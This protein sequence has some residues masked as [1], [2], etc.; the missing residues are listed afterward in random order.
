MEKIIKIDP[1]LLVGR[2]VLINIIS[3]L[4]SEF[5]EKDIILCRDEYVR[6]NTLSLFHKIF[7]DITIIK[8][9]NKND[10]TIDFVEQLSNFSSATNIHSKINKLVHD[11]YKFFNITFFLDIIFQEK[12]FFIDI[13]ERREIHKYI[14][15]FFKYS[16]T[17]IQ[18]KM[19]EKS[20]HL[21]DKD[22]KDFY[23]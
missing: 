1:E 3:K 6:Q 5:K 4:F 23:L 2:G 22:E 15:G 8:S 18:G 11:Y 21:Y 10:N 13:S 12:E 16:I 17:D 14:Y 19:I 9:F 7:K 20:T